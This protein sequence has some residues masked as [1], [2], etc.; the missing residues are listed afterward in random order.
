MVNGIF[1]NP[2][3]GFETLTDAILNMP[4]LP[5]R[6]RALG[7]FD[8]QGVPTTSI[9][10]ESDGVTL[11]LIPATER[12]APAAKYKAQKRTMRNLVIPHLQV[13]DTIKPE[14][15]Q[16][17]REFGSNN[18]LLSAQAVV[19]QRIQ[20]MTTNH[21]ATLE[22]GSIGAV[23]GVIYDADGATVIYDLF[24]E[25]GVGQTSVDFA[26]SNDATD[27]KGKCLQVVRAVEVELGASIYDHVHCF[28][29]KDWFDDFV[30]H[31]AVK[32]AYE[33]W[34][35]SSGQLGAFLRDDNRKG[36]AFAGIVFEEYRG[37]VS[38]V[39]FIAD[40]EAHFFPVGVPKLFKTV[41]AP[42]NFWETVNT[43]GLPRYARLELL[44]MGRGCNILT[45]SNPLSYCTKPKTL[46]KG[47]TS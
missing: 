36:F 9:D 38:G 4:F 29:G 24:A 21:D 47:T 44:D 16:N 13:E 1:A 15:I 27:V 11:S 3:F 40:A 8:N 6:C 14:S 5:G 46:V 43:I 25:F 26:L 28:C 7:I 22:Y 2:A 45:E 42:G 31:P 33:R 34:S 35:D 41:Y 17:V 19:N 32:T 37:N 20:G 23:K 10:L 18:Q 30:N 39:P 12:G